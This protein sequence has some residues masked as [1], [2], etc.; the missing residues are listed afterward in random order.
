MDSFKKIL[1][2]GAAGF[3][4][5]HLCKSLLDDGYKVLGIDNLNDY[6]NSELKQARLKKL[7]N[8]KNFFFKK[9]DISNKKE[10][11]LEF[12]SFKPNKVVHLAA[13]AGV[14]YSIK[15]PY[16]YVNSNLVN[17]FII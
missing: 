9:I 14:R 2:T 1:I 12:C 8:Y 5:F 10:L 3:I 17:K 16:A 13:Q 4:G 7:F 15:N 11:S 6:Y